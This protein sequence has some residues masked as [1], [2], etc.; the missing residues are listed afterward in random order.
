MRPLRP[1][2]E[3]GCP[4]AYLPLS[5]AASPREV[6]ETYIAGMRRW[7]ELARSGKRGVAISPNI[8]AVNVPPTPEW[9]E[10][11]KVRLDGLEQAIRPFFR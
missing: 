5:D 6:F 2:G 11:L 8:P 4:S 7:V 10:R 1:C 9:A 3:W